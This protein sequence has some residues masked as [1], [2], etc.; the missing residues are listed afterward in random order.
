MSGLCGAGDGS[1]INGCAINSVYYLAQLT[2]IDRLHVNSGGGGVKDR[3]TEQVG[4]C[5][6]FFEIETLHPKRKLLELEGKQLITT[7]ESP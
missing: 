3:T 4:W 6:S 1:L 2:L 5:N 7:S